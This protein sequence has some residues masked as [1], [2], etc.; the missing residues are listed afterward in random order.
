MRKILKVKDWIE[1]RYAVEGVMHDW[2]KRVQGDGSLNKKLKA[3]NL[4]PIVDPVTGELNITFKVD[5]GYFS[6]DIFLGTRE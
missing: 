3:Q 5:P 6:Q 1:N 2:L 4:T